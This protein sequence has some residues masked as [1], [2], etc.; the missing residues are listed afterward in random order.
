MY[1][2][3]FQGQAFVNDFNIGRYWPQEGPQVTLYVP[4]PVLNATGTNQLLVLEL[5]HSPCSRTNATLCTVS[6]LDYPIIDGK[7]SGKLASSWPK[8]DWASRTVH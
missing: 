3:L 1:P 8:D 5:E 2:M 4:A 6:F 7:T